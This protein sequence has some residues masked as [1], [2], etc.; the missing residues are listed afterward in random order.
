MIQVKESPVPSDTLLTVDLKSGSKVKICTHTIRPNFCCRWLGWVFRCTFALIDLK[1]KGETNC[2]LKILLL[3]LW[4]E[5]GW[6]GGVGG[7]RE[8]GWTDKRVGG[9]KS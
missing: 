4:K 6:E 9:G 3:S 8:G 7:G 2:S 1:L 5:V